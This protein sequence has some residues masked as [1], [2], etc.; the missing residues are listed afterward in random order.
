MSQTVCRETETKVL[1]SGTVKHIG[2]TFNL[3]TFKVILG[4]FGAPVVKISVT[5]KTA[6]R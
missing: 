4:L 3:V 6:G 1:D 2:N 5:I